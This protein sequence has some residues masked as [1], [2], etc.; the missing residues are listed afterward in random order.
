[1]DEA[2]PA[3]VPVWARNHS[4]TNNPLDPS[5]HKSYTNHIV[6]VSSHLYMLYLPLTAHICALLIFLCYYY[7]LK[8]QHI[9]LQ[10]FVSL[11]HDYEDF[12]SVLRKYP[13]PVT[14]FNKV[15]IMH[16]ECCAKV[17]HLRMSNFLFCGRPNPR[18]NI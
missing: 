12:I 4:P 13:E 2:F 3:E 8:L 10:H 14:V 6:N 17:M 5:G 7:Y 18:R 15:I 16:N 9:F 11:F 1:M